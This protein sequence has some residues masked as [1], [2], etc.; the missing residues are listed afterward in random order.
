MSGELLRDVTRTG[1]QAGRSPRRWPLIPLSILAHVIAAGVVIVAPL[2]AAIELPVPAP[3]PAQRPFLVTAA[4]DINLPAPPMARPPQPAFDPARAPLAAPPTIEPEAP[5]VASGPPA[6]GA[7]PGLGNGVSSGLGL[8]DPLLPSVPRPEPPRPPAPPE[9]RRVGGDI[10][11]PERIGGAVPVYPEIARRAR[12]D[13]VVILE[14]LIDEHGRV[15]RLKV[16]RSEPLLDAA[17]LDAVATWR[18]T[19]PML[20]G[21][22]IP[23]LMTVTVRFNLDR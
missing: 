21:V 20:N 4:R 15:G 18:Y 1:E 16:L 23:V 7:V 13:G 3:L 2:T 17:A 14:A 6:D 12:V 10:R 19:P 8:G 11:P 9:P 22:P 5:V